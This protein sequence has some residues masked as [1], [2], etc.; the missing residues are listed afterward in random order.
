VTYREHASPPWPRT[1]DEVLGSRNVAA[2]SDLGLTDINHSVLLGS[3]LPDL[4]AVI[5]GHP[6]S[7]GPNGA[8]WIRYVTERACC[9]PGCMRLF[10]L[11]TA[12]IVDGIADL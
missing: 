9:N 2:Q 6:C 11:A 8:R 10:T 3:R 5:A 12:P 4:F 1:G 7:A